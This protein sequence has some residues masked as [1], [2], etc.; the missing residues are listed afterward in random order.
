MSALLLRDGGLSEH[1]VEEL[2]S[3]G[4]TTIADIISGSVDVI[5]ARTPT[6]EK[7]A[8]QAAHTQAAALH[9]ARPRSCAQLWSERMSTAFMVPTC[10]ELDALIGG[11]FL[12]GEV[13]EIAGRS[14]VGKTRV[15]LSVCAHAALVMRAP[16]LYID[17]T[18]S[19][20]AQRLA[21]EC[22]RIAP[23]RDA[24]DMTT[25][26]DALGRVHVLRLHE[27][28]EL[29]QALAR[30]HHDQLDGR[31]WAADLTA[32]IVDCVS[33]PLVPIL[34]RGTQ[35]GQMWMLA[36]SQ[37]LHD[38]AARNVAVLVANTV[39]TADK[40]NMC[41]GVTHSCIKAAL[42]LSWRSV[43]DVRVLMTLN[44]IP[45]RPR[46]SL[47]SPAD[48]DA[49]RAERVEARGA[50]T[51]QQSAVVSAFLEKSG[52]CAVGQ[53]VWVRAFCHPSPTPAS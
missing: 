53:C 29:V 42:G 43:S 47:E 19:F 27:T 34:A 22:R 33:L 4:I 15:C 35:T 30:A 46:T 24:L 3:R 36:L 32:V 20:S 18:N 2:V 39:V 40:Q 48:G 17:T 28:D 45:A 38:I 23:D 37:L 11:G 51:P 21:Y 5:S 44:A 6:V 10:T 52:R 49:E 41:E 50:A 13:S 1:D 25:L 31:G 26:H 12:S 7:S 9:A 14:G 8:L 16:V